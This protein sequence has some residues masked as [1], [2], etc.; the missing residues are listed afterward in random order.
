MTFSTQQNSNVI[1]SVVDIRYASTTAAAVLA[2]LYIF[3]LI[4]KKMMQPIQAF[5]RLRK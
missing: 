2:L 4:L 3:Y 1:L 5:I